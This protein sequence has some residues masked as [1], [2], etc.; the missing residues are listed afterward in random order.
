MATWSSRR[1]VALAAALAVFATIIGL[2]Q[3]VLGQR[4]A[5]ADDTCPAPEKD[6]TSAVS[7]DY[8]NSDLVDDRGKSVRT[9]VN[10]QTVGV[11][12]PWSTSAP[13]KAG[14]YFTYDAT[15]TDKANGAKPISPTA[16]KN[17]PVQS[18]D[19]TVV[20]CGTWGT[21]GKV[22]VVFT[23]SAEQAASW[24]GTVSSW[25]QMRYDGDSITTPTYLIGGKKEIKTE[26]VGSLTPPGNATS[27]RKDGWMSIQ[28]SHNEDQA[29]T[30]RLIVPGG[31]SGVRGATIVDSA[32]GGNWDFTCDKVQSFV[33]THSYLVEGTATGAQME[34]D[35]TAGAFAKGV[36]VTCEGSKVTLKL[37]DIPAGKFGVVMLPAHV[38]GASADNPLSGTFENSAVLSV[39][40]KEDQKATRFMRYGALGDAEAHQKFSVTKKLEGTADASL[41]YTLNITVSN[42]ADPTVDRTYTAT[43]KAGETFTSA[44]SLP[45]GTK[46]TIKEG[47]LPGT[48]TW[49]TARSGIFE[50]ADGV[51]LS[52]DAREATFTLAQDRVFSLTLVNATTPAPGE[53]TTPTPQESTTTPAA[54]A[55]TTTPAPA[56]QPKPKLA[57]TGAGTIAIGALAGLLAIAGVAT[58]V[59]R[60]R[61]K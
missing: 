35:T 44:D 16:A 43:L 51:T 46:V 48:V 53:S 47:D 59:A 19:G 18:S 58:L 42:E 61:Q 5:H 21:D 52:A 1:W 13:V 27:F 24:T 14:D 12:M 25:G 34:K 56:A 20:G 2:G 54:T 37:P 41:E 4:A 31:E 39:P 57:N 7:V 8:D 22:T 60:R 26:R 29:I 23:K 36:G 45:L 50:A 32:V 38:A 6:I 17:F 33:P 49:D 40:G 11:K 30:Y 15:V 55:T 3:V 28:Y 10:W 9:F